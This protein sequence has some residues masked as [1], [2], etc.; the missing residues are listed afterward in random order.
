M[1][2]P[3]TPTQEQAMLKNIGVFH[4][5]GEDRTKPLDRSGYPSMKPAGNVP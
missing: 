5:G 1:I 4:Y 3:S 2:A